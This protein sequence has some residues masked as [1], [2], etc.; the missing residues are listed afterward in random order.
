MNTL[1]VSTKILTD[2]VQFFSGRD[3]YLTIGVGI[4]SG[5]R[6]A[7][8]NMAPVWVWSGVV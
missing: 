2:L 4:R 5:S 1:E 3:R 7:S 6:R 8:V